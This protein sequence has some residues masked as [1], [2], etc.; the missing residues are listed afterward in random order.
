MFP[1]F[2]YN[3]ILLI[4]DTIL[5]SFLFQLLYLLEISYII[6]KININFTIHLIIFEKIIFWAL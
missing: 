2:S 6:Q 4:G 3:F 5:F 1:N